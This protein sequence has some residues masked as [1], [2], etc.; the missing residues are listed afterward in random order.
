MIQNILPQLKPHMWALVVFLGVTIAYFY[1]A[2]TGYSLKQADTKNWQGM[3]HEVVNYRNTTGE[4]S[5]WT[6]SMFGG[7]PAYQISVRYA[8]PVL[9]TIDKA[10]TLFIPNISR[11]FFLYLISFYLMG[12]LMGWDYRLSIVGALAFAFSTYFIVILEAGH[13]SKAHAIGYMP[14]VFGTYWKLWRSDKKLLYGSLFGL[15]LALEIWCNHV[16]I[17]YYLGFLLA[18]FSLFKLVS[19]LK[20]GQ[21]KALVRTIAVA[22]VAVILAVFSNISSL[23]NTYQYGKATTRGGAV[24]S[25]DP[26][27]NSTK[28]NTTSGLDRDYVVQWS[29]GLEES[30]TLLIPNAK[31]GATQVIGQDNKALSKAPRNMQPNVA[32]SNQYWGNQAFTSGP[33]YVGAVVFLLFIFAC[34]YVQGRLKWVLI[35]STLLALMLSWGKNFMGLTNFFLDY[36]PGYNKFRAVTI[37]LSLLELTIPILAFLGLQ[38]FIKEKPIW[39]D[40]K[41]P[42]Y[43]SVGSLLGLMVLFS[44]TPDT[45]FSFLSEA[46]QSGLQQQAQGGNAAQIQAYIDAL[47]AVR[48]KIFTND[49]YRSI[50]FMI[51]AAA[52]LQAWSKQWIKKSW[53]LIAAIGILVLADLWPVNARY[54]STEKERGQYVNWE[55]NLDSAVPVP[56]TA[57][58]EEIFRRE[59]QERPEIMTKAQAAIQE[60]RANNP[61]MTPAEESRIKFATLNLETN[62]RVLNLTRSTFND[63][64]TSYYHK[65][66]GGYHGAKLRRYQDLIEFYFSGQ[67]NFQVLN[68]LNTKYIIQGQGGAPRVIPNPD[69]FGNAWFV[70]RVK[71]VADAN[72]AILA[73]D[74]NKSDLSQEAVI[75]T[76]DFPEMGAK[77]YSVDSTASINLVSYLP[78][79]LVYRSNANSEQLAVFSEIYFQPGWTA[80]IDGVEAPHVRANYL[81]RAME[82]PAG[83][84]EIVFEFN[85]PS[86]KTGNAINIASSVLLALLLAFGIYKEA[87]IEEQA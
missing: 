30:F 71:P 45:F 67:L 69:R 6:N 46:E 63:A 76:S 5:L 21:S 14:L 65:S 74:E 29:Y 15:A 38:K 57:V 36:L 2:Y 3:S 81:L 9:K 16:Q 58:D 18:I 83:E 86:Y 22:G 26:S 72:E 79:K 4:Q 43:I 59:L 66:I 24:L 84:H 12:L 52:L 51:A 27:G 70:S 19:H 80:Y 49:A 13:N 37:I 33:V 48:I 31:G 85:P 87:K 11:L 44:L 61:R 64:F 25:I 32:Q 55:R 23:Y 35:I 10:L 7:M 41:K 42:F 8:D 60:A 62:Y 54:L 39:E 75:N 50:F 78:N 47:K 40:I 77:Q 17:T 34:V 56:A 68:M 1:P 28:D 82:V 20:E 73:L 53:H